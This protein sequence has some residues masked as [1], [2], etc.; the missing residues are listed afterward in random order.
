MPE[1]SGGESPVTNQASASTSAGS[2]ACH[3]NY[4]VTT[5]W[6][7]G[8]G[9]SLSIKNTGP[10]SVNG[11]TITWTWAEN[12]AITES[13][14]S[15]YTQHGE[16]AAL[17]NMSYNSSFAAGATISGIGFNAS[18]SGTNTSPTTFYVNGVA[19]H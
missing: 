1:N 10:V 5:Q 19:C 15:N 7:V 4:T 11:W 18:Y 8:F 16:N 6:N 14:N 17:T 2:F 13:W 9:T 3:V 12:Q